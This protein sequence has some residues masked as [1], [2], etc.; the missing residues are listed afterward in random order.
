MASNNSCDFDLGTSGQV[1]TSN[2]AGSAPTMQDVPAGFFL[3]SS[4][5][6]SGDASLEFT[7]LSAGSVYCF[8]FNGIIPATNDRDLYAQVS[9]DNGSTYASSSYQS[10]I[11]AMVY[12]SNAITNYNDTTKI[13]FV[14]AGMSA[15]RYSGG[16]LYLIT[17]NYSYFY[18]TFV[19]STTSGK[20]FHQ[21]MGT[22]N[23]STQPNAIKFYCE[24]ASNFS[25]TI[26]LYKLG[27]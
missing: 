1:L 24:S 23:N 12:D 13:L 15:S 14:S 25:G 17:N 5:T 9:T 7:N 20:T 4:Q 22:Y 26:S 18:G 16:H 6:A 8:T 11:Q 19:M 3:V 27:T 2:G 21:I 10:G